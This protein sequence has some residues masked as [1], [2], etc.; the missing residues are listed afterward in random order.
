MQTVKIAYISGRRKYSRG[1]A[2]P[3]PGAPRNPEIPKKIMPD[4]RPAIF[5]QPNALERPGWF[6]F[7]IDAEP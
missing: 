7:Y 3:S 1:H 6:V 5:L 2:A 4:A